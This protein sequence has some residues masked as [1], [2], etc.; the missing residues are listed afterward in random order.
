MLVGQNPDGF[1][2]AGRHR[3]GEA[4]ILQ[5]R[6]RTDPECQIVIDDKDR[7]SRMFSHG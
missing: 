7:V 6:Q 4:M 1:L 5:H 2:A 3:S